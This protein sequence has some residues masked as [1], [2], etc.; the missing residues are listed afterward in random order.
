MP[1]DKELVIVK[2]SFFTKIRNFF[3]NLFPK[4]QEREAYVDLKENKDIKKE[5]FTKNIKVEE[6]KEIT[7]LLSLQ[8]MLRNK[9]IE[10]KDITKED[11]IK[12]RDLY[13]KQISDLK[14]KI[15]EHRKAIIKI[16][17]KLETNKV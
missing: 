4:E 16:K 17:I 5:E 11:E 3:K 10:E 14:E 15:E 7:K 8:S 9:Q 6:D 2:E 12:L 1:K 13:K